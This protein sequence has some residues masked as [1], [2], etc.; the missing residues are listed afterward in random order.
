[1]ATVC[2]STCVTAQAQ[3][4]M[5][6]DPF[7]AVYDRNSVSL[8]YNRVTITPN[9][10]TRLSLSSADSTIQL[11]L[12]DSVFAQPRD[13]LIIDSKFLEDARQRFPDAFVVTHPHLK[14][15]TYAYTYSTPDSIFVLKFLFLD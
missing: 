13:V 10:R 4:H 7:R 3:H 9:V 1:M 15:G 8:I 6:T 12:F 5:A 14:S 2:A 11:C